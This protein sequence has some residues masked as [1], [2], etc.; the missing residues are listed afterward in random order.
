MVDQN[1]VNDLLLLGP[2]LQLGGPPNV[3]ADIRATRGANVVP[4]GAHANA[5]QLY[6][7][8]GILSTGLLTRNF[9]VGGSPNNPHS[10]N[11]NIIAMSNAY[12]DHFVGAVTSV[13][14][15]LVNNGVG[16]YI[17]WNEPH[18]ANP[19]TPGALAPRNFAALLY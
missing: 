8:N 4:T 2:G 19:P 17:I 15:Q 7:S 3:R 9:D 13:I 11:D 1:S 10:E 14:N 16:S 18:A 12:I 6:R 5:L